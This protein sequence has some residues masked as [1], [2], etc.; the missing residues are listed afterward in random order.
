MGRS[1]PK[2]IIYYVQRY[3]PQYEAISKEV[4]LLANHFK[5]DYP[6]KIKD[7][8]LQRLFEFKFNSKITS[9]HFCWYPLGAIFNRIFSYGS[10]INHIYTSLG[11]LP[12]L[13]VINLRNTILTA[14]ASC[15]FAKTK[16]R[17]SYLRKLK[18]II[19]E[20]QQHKDYLL[21]LGI[22]ERRIKVIYPP[23]DLGK[24][25]YHLARGNFKIVYASCPVKESD[26]SKRGINLLLQAAASSNSI[27]WTLVWRKGSFSKIVSLLNHLKLNNVTISNNIFK[28][29]NPVYSA[30]H[31]A[32]IPYTRFDDHL[33]LIPNSAVESLAAGKPVLISSKTELSKIIKANHCGVVFEPNQISLMEAV[34]ELKR[35]YRSYQKNCRSTAIKLFSKDIFIKKYQEVYR[36][37]DKH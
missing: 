29:M 6:I 9:Y 25:S 26:F 22:P 23:V 15:S 7:L 12:Y 24:F 19:V 2:K 30:V 17:I 27:H 20:T 4:S 1:M 13:K 10:N 3:R 5:K 33:K 8:H 14:A 35:N 37:F 18:Q 36:E 21:K 34:T 11:D 31:A 32:I 28:D 16:K